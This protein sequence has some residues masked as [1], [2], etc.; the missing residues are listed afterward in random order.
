M[1]FYEEFSKY[2][3]F[4]FPTGEAQVN[5]IIKHIPENKRN[6][7]DVACG[8]G[9]Y[10]IALAKKNIEVSAVDLDEKMI[11]ETISK[12]H[13][14]NVHVDA[15][16][17]DMTALNEVFPHEKFG[18]IFCIGNSLVHLTKLVD[19]EEAL[20]QMYHLLEEEGSLILQIINY[21][22]IL[23]YDINGLPTIDNKEAGVKFIRRYEP[24]QRV[25]L[26]NFNTELIINDGEAQ[27]VYRN[28]VPLYLLQQEQLEG[29]LRVVGFRDMNFFG[30]FKE[31][32]YSQEA[33]ATVVV[34]KK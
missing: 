20:R 14:N 17:G 18:S 6:V 29:L 16:T 11:Q 15:N 33:Y 27:R 2:Y 26:I 23:K 30:S 4:I 25:G 31:E 19:M 1:T 34:A 7:L 3:D 5:L 24:N 8:T 32:P 21:D 9:N 10:A 13:E 12:S 28:S 22:R